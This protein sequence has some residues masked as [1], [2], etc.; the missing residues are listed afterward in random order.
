M[1]NTLEPL[2][3]EKYEKQT[4]NK[5]TVYK[6]RLFFNPENPLIQISTDGIAIKLNERKTNFEKINFEAKCY[7]IAG[8]FHG[9]K[10]TADYNAQ[11][12]GQMWVM[13][14]QLTHFACYYVPHQ[15]FHI[16]PVE[17]DE[18]FIKDMLYEVNLAWEEVE[19]K[20]KELNFNV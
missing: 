1:G 7:W 3:V 20:R 9:D 15:K 17:R 12:Q 19:A 18:S 2:L 14:L 13:G 6:D 10:M 5:V 16:I 4:G 11:S 8:K